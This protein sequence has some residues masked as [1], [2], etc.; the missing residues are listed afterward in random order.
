MD[1]RLP[2]CSLVLFALT[3]SVASATEIVLTAFEPF[4]GDPVNNSAEVVSRLGELLE[5]P[6]PR[7]DQRIVTECILPVEYDR[8]AAVALEC[9]QGRK[10]D[11]VLSFGAGG[12]E[13]DFE[14]RGHNRDRTYAADNAGVIRDSNSAIIPGAPE[15]L[16]FNAP[17]A[18]IFEHAVQY[19]EAKL[20][21]SE[22]AGGYVCNNTAYLLAHAFARPNSPTR[23]GFIHVPPTT[24]G[25]GMADPDLLARTIN[26][27]LRAAMPEL[28]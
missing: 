18:A 24:C 12:C 10:P 28:F 22:D 15:Y 11:L 25:S 21:P 14:T 17:M 2:F 6:S 7:G 8:G 1:V 16:Y 26:D 23:F 4:G 9:I 20:A 19:T 13:V 3:T 27:A 5:R